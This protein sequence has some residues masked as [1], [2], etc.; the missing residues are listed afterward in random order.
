MVKLERVNEM[1]THA[2]PRPPGG[3]PVAP[4]DMT[5][6]D[7]ENALVDGVASTGRASLMRVWRS[8]FGDFVSA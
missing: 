7:A 3:A 4:S 2:L 8:I 6:A 5:R 1:F